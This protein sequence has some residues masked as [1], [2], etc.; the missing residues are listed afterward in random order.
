MWGRGGP[1]V[2]LHS[3]ST[4]AVDED[5]WPASHPFR[6]TLGDVGPGLS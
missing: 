3:L 1:G 2:E 5:T 6:F 4:S